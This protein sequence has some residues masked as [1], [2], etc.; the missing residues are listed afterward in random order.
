MS[1]IPGADALNKGDIFNLIQA[2]VL[3]AQQ[4]VQLELGHHRRVFTVEIFLR[5]IFLGAGGQNGDAVLDE[6]GRAIGSHLGLK[7]T[8]KAL[9]FGDGGIEMHRH[10]RLSFDFLR[11]LLEEAADILAFIGMEQ[12]P[13]GAAEHV[14]PLHQI[15]RISLPGQIQGGGHPGHP[16]AHHQGGGGYRQFLLVERSQ[17]GAFG[18]RH[19]HQVLGLLRGHLRLLGMDPGV[20]ITDVGHLKQILVQTGVNQGFLEQRL[21]GAG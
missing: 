9:H 15:H 14:A 3:A 1:F 4:F 20:L 11:Q 13:G 7:I 6:S 17:E 21:V 18:H 2:L 16:P 12:P 8:D 19:P 10:L 5:L